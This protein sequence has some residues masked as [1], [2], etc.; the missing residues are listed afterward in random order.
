MMTCRRQRL[1]AAIATACVALASPLSPAMAQGAPAGRGA[2][3]EVTIYRDAKGVPHIVGS[4]SAAVMYG[5]GYS[6]VQD[7]L[8]QLELARRGK[9]GTR[10]EILGPRMVEADKQA[11]NEVLPDAELLRMYGALSAEH[12]A[13]LQAFVDG[14]NRGV[15]EVL[16]DPEHKLPYE[17]KAW[18]VKPTRW[19]LA[20]YLS[21]ISGPHG[22]TYELQNLAFLNAMVARY[23]PTVGRQ[24]FNDVVPI[25]D[26]DTPLII[27]PGEDQG[28]KAPAPKGVAYPP[29]PMATAMAALQAAPRPAEAVVG[30]SRC[31]AIGP[32]KSASGRP[33]LMEATS[34]GPEAH[35]LGGG[36]DTVGFSHSG[37]GPPLMGRSLQHGWLMTSGH[38]GTTD[39]YAEKLN[40]ADKHQYWFK[41]EWRR[42]EVRTETI[43]VKGGEP[44]A[45]EVAWTVHGP[46]IQWD[47]EHGVAYS[48]RNNERGYE[49]DSWVGVVEMA[50]AK[51]LKEFEAKGVARVAWNLGVCYGDEAGNIGFWEAGKLP[52]RPANADSRL[53]MPGTGEYE[54]EGFHSAQ[55]MPRMINPK[56][57][58]IHT[59]NGK[60]AAWLP[61]GDDA[62][63]GKTYRTWLGNKLAAA[64]RGMTLLDMREINR[65][66]WNAEGARDRAQTSPD[67]F[68][69]Y[70]RA[71]IARSSDAEVKQALE[72]M[73][74]FNGMYEDLDGDGRYDNAGGTLW[75]EWLLTAPDV[76]FSPQLGDWW[77]KVDE[78]RYHQYRTSLLLRAV[79]G[80]DAGLPLQFDYFQGRDRDAVIAQ[81]I[82]ATIDKVK[83]K[84]PGQP[85]AAWRAPIFWKYFDAGKFDPARPAMP[86]EDMFRRTASVLGLAPAMVPH[87]GGEG[88]V[89]MMELNPKDRALFSVVEAGGQNLFIDQAGK[90][91]PNLSDQL[92]MHAKNEFKRIDMTLETIKRDAVSTTKLTF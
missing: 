15:D 56:Q 73:L 27:P 23:G 60:A 10:A 67:F 55:D 29:A 61:E 70:L 49:L 86:N 11:R 71:A 44:V 48:Q 35:L 41:G 28:L 45:Y 25:S 81:T 52:K 76:V 87:H 18:G 83:P 53:P 34:D 57:G 36:F 68:A 4:T 90:G 65:E 88:W 38:A 7:R 21:H 78:D 1:L 58:Y 84:Y 51:T 79:Q 47:V 69:P 43:K 32:G 91:N 59:W 72:L 3:R 39:T 33:L 63:I 66:I 54:W 19:T 50:R 82:R 92:P 64:G 31:L 22:N 80:K 13:M 24:I 9:K 85:M 89:G 20:D 42:M 75:R 62:R 2:D 17:F 14:L 12:Q 37:W 30:A 40:P 16:A 46:V 74:S 26:P 77:E 6:L 8:A 5:L